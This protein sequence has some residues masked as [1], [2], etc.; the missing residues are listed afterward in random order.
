MRSTTPKNSQIRRDGRIE[1]KTKEKKQNPPHLPDR[2]AGNVSR[3]VRRRYTAATHGDSV[4]VTSVLVMLVMDLG[5]SEDDDSA[6][7]NIKCGP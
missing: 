4:R 1:I 7:I 5:C 2:N 3:R 6:C